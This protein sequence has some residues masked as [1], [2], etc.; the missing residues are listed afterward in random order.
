[1]AR[2]GHLSHPHSGDRGDGAALR[3]RR[4]AWQ[5]T[6]HAVYAVFLATAGESVIIDSDHWR[7]YF[8]IIGVLWG[9]IAAF[10]GVRF[11]ARTAAVRRLAKQPW[12]K[13]H[14]RTRALARVHEP[15]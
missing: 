1:M 8:L 9:L 4:N 12:G 14:G 5:S 15:A 6:Y 13:A 2:R 10:A 7:H 3:A 11:R